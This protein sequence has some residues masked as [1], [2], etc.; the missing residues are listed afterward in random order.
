M[1]EGGADGNLF[2]DEIVPVLEEMER[3]EELRS[4][5]VLMK[6]IKPET[7][8]WFSNLFCIFINIPQPNTIVRAG[9]AHP[10]DTIS[11]FGIFGV[12]L[13]RKG[14][15]ESI[16]NCAEGHLVRTKPANSDKGG[17]AVGAAAI[18]SIS[19]ASWLTYRVPY[20]WQ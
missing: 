5:Y 7:R 18:S 13:H 4:K 9:V 6:L 12:Y 14:E 1:R 15:L 17:V 10:G 2:R 11:E 16:V 3:N 20:S 19:I 8:V